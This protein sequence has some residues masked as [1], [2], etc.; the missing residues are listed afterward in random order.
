[1]FTAV[2]HSCQ[3]LCPRVC[4]GVHQHLPSAS[5]CTFLNP[6]HDIAVAPMFSLSPRGVLVASRGCTAPFGVSGISYS[7]DE[8]L[9]VLSL[10]SSFS[11]P[12]SPSPQFSVIL[13]A[14][15]PHFHF[16]PNL[17]RTPSFSLFA[18][19]PSVAHG[20]RDC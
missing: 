7:R 11:L 3:P 10:S 8:F 12:L 4:V 17:C 9:P 14:E 18:H 15:C 16:V 2:C 13:Q 20:L 5:S 6:S 19:G 1:M